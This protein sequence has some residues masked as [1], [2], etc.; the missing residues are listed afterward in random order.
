MG[1]KNTPD[2]LPLPGEIL[3]RGEALRWMIRV[4]WSWDLIDSIMM[5]DCP[6]LETVRRLVYQYGPEDARQ[7]MIRMLG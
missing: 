6:D 1:R 3:S 5:H 7:R 2:Y 4:G